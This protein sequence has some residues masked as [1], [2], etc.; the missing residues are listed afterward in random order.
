[1][2][3]HIFIIGGIAIL[4]LA[5]IDS[6]GISLEIPTSSNTTNMIIGAGMIAAP[7]VYSKVV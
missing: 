4:I 1:M 2:V 5:I 3:K 7:Y 6:M